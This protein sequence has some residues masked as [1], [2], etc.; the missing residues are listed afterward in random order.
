[1][2]LSKPMKFLLGRTRGV[3]VLAAAGLAVLALTA[4]RSTAW[5]QNTVGT[6][7]ELKGSAH[8]ER[9]G[10][11]LPIT[12][13]MPLLLHDKIV[14][15]PDSE[16]VVGVLDNSRLTIEASTTLTIDESVVVGGQSAPT[17]VGL[18]KGTLHSLVLGELRTAR[19]GFEVHTPNAVA[20]VRGTDFTVTVSEQPQAKP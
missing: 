12:A 15:D 4:G 6:V 8:V 2:L 10:N 20:A 17:K 16:V 13:G 3:R 7:M 18:L 5:A 11:T 19:G 1:M 9:G 14:T